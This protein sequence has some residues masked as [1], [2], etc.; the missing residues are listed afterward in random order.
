MVYLGI[1]LGQNHVISISNL[2]FQ[3]RHFALAS[4]YLLAPGRVKP[5]RPPKNR[6]FWRCCRS[7]MPIWRWSKRQMGSERELT[8]ILR[9]HYR[10]SHTISMLWYVHWQFGWVF[11]IAVVR[12]TLSSWDSLGFDPQFLGHKKHQKT[13]VVAS[14]VKHPGLERLFGNEAT[15]LPTLLL[16]LQRQSAGD[17]ISSPANKS[18][19]FRWW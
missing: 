15:G 5:W 1:Y 17:S 16:P 12:Y 9:A 11:E 10:H 18:F 14:G 4:L 3:T 7:A 19:F 13:S 8:T 6:D 2:S